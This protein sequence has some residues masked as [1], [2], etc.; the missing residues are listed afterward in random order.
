MPYKLK[1][2]YGNVTRRVDVEEKF[3]IGGPD[4]TFSGLE[5][6]IRG[7]FELPEAFKFDMV[8]TDNDNDGVTI[9]DNEDFAKACQDLDSDFIRVAVL[10]RAS[11]RSATRGRPVE[12][13]ADAPPAWAA[14][15][16][17]K[18]DQILRALS[19][20]VAEPR[21]QSV[22]TPRPSVGNQRP[23]GGSPRHQGQA[24]TYRK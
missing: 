6:T 15:I 14:E 5:N 24:S 20:R 19:G 9:T 1:I 16:I 23:V 21:V 11:H 4:L 2:T 22:Y 8:Y 13:S 7:L 18:L 10:D 3:Y 17:Q 12:S